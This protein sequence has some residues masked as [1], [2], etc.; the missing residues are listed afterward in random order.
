MTSSI[1]GNEGKP[2]S[3]VPTMKNTPIRIEI[4]ISYSLAWALYRNFH[5]EVW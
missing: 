4:K 1:K 2:K 3:G 5:E